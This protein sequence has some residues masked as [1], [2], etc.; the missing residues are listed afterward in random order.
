MSNKLLLYLDLADMN[1]YDLFFMIFTQCLFTQE[2]PMSSPSPKRIQL[3]AQLWKAPFL[4]IEIKKMGRVKGNT[5]VNHRQ[6]GE[7]SNSS[8][9]R[10]K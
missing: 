9:V 8:T 3:S 6:K 7:Q 1:L 10:E 2:L 4:E 5:S